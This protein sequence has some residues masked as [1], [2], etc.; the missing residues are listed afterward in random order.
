VG[1]IDI[2]LMG[3]SVWALGHVTEVAEIA[4]IYY[5]PVVLF[6]YTVHFHGI[7]FV[8][9]VKQG[10][11]TLAQADTASA[12]VTEIEYTFKL[13]EQALLAGV[14]RAFPIDWMPCGGFEIALSLTCRTCHC[15]SSTSWD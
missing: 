1:K 12:A 8:N 10:R 13:L 15:V 2:P 9:Q 3:W 14:V 5:L 4:V 6:R 7:R 11:K